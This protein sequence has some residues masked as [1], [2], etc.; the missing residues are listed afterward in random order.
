MSFRDG[1]VFATYFS[2]KGNAYSAQTPR[3]ASPPLGLKVLEPCMPPT[4]RR[5]ASPLLF[6]AG[7]PAPRCGRHLRQ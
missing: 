3:L 6:L 5:L 4:P 2:R 7:V 1:V